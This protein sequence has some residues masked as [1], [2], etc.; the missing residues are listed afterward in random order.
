MGLLRQQ[1][2]T[3]FKNLQYKH[4]LPWAARGQVQTRSLELMCAFTDLLSA[5]VS[6]SMGM[7]SRTKYYNKRGLV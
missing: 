1:E 2:N 3:K 5:G 4:E 6:L 7:S